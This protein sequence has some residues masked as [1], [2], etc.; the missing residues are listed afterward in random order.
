M[1]SLKF[2][3]WLVIVF[4]VT[5]PDDFG[6]CLIVADELSPMPIDTSGSGRVRERA[7]D[8]NADFHRGRCTF[9][10][11]TGGRSCQIESSRHRKLNRDNG[12]CL[13]FDYHSHG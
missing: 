1:I 3:S 7:G 6:L 12:R 11:G 5:Q 10:K 4:S 13:M 8:E 2:I 9:P